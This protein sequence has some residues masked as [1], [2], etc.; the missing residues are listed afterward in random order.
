MENPPPFKITPN[1][2]RAM[3]NILQTERRVDGRQ[4]QETR[5]FRIEFSTNSAVVHLGKTLVTCTTTISQE[6]PDDDRPSEG[7][8]VISI[9]SPHKLDYSFQADTVYQLRAALHHTRALDLESLVIK[10]GELVWNLK[11]DIV[12]QN[13]DGGLIEAC[14]LALVSSLLST[15]LPGPR[16]LR[17]IVIHHLP[18]AITFGFLEAHLIFVDPT[19]KE[20]SVLKGFLTIFAN[21]QGEICAIHKNG[22]L[23]VRQNV[24]DIAVDKAFEIVRLWHAELMKQMGP[25]APPLLKQIIS[26]KSEEI[27]ETPKTEEE[28]QREVVEEFQEAA[29]EED[30]EDEDEEVD[31]SLLSLLQ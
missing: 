3:E 11:S 25:N 22:G 4:P 19:L 10:I 27:M 20:S 29:K 12:I 9:S 13:N 26:Q 2:M 14:H 30:Y 31:P 16:G 18:I 21:A 28:I 23:P 8:H 15:K 7:R 17:A 5:Y 6:K 1:E 24:I